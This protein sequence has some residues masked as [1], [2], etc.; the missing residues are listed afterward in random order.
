MRE[1][2]IDTETNGPDPTEHDRVANDGR[3]GAIIKLL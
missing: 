3:L 2:V 1:I